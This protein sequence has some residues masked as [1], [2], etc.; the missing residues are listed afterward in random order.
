VEANGLTETTSARNRITYAPS[1]T[2][3][4]TTKHFVTTPNLITE[5]EQI[6]RDPEAEAGQGDDNQGVDQGANKDIMITVLDT[7]EKRQD[8]VLVTTTG[9][10]MV[11]DIKTNQLKEKAV[12]KLDAVTVNTTNISINNT[13]KKKH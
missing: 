2:E 9:Q 4:V 11:D 6:D 5:K 13:E 3:S 12:E 7:R 8:H 1:A 10:T